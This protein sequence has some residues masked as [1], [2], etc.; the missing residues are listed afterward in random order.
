VPKNF[1]NSPAA[2]FMVAIIF[3]MGGILF[4]TYLPEFALHATKVVIGEGI[5]VMI[6]GLFAWGVWLF[7]EQKLYG[8]WHIRVT[9]LDGQ[10]EIDPVPPTVIKQWHKAK[11]GD[12]GPHGWRDICATLDP[13]DN[14]CPPIHVDAREARRRGALVVDAEDKEV[15]IDY[16][17]MK[18]EAERVQPLTA[19][20]ASTDNPDE[21]AKSAAPQAEAVVN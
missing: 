6:A 16:N 2:F 12:W 19:D 3:L 4:A 5:S 15:R 11:F 17:L 10:V 13:R 7:R 14:G 20:H 1:R 9:N 8:D 21:G 18:K